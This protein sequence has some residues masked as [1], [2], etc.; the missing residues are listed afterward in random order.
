MTHPILPQTRKRT[1]GADKRLSAI[2]SIVYGGYED[3]YVIM[4]SFASKMGIKP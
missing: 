4:G 2:L 1:L 3:G